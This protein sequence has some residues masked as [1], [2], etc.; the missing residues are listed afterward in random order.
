MTR[1]FVDAN[2]ALYAVARESTRR[3]PCRLVLTGIARGDI[4]GWT[5]VQVLQ[6]V[7]HRCLHASRAGRPEALGGYDDFLALFPRRVI[8]IDAVDLARARELAREHGELPSADLVHLATMER[9][10]ITAIIT[11]DRHF[12]GIKGVEL[13]DP[14]KLARRISR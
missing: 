10:E 1:A 14:V 2:V 3:E 11:A 8:P 5:N 6:E 7:L 13:L 9:H 4:D 12:D